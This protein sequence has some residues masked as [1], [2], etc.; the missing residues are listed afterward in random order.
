MVTT[1]TLYAPPEEIR[2]AAQREFCLDDQ[3]SKKDR[4]G[5]GNP[6]GIGEDQGAA[7]RSSDLNNNNK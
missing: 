1:A 3:S 4:R 7:S 6:N 5:Q 2:R